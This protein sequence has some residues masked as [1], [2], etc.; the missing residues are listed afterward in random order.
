[1][2][3]LP[4]LHLLQELH[5][6]SLAAHANN[7]LL[8]QAYMLNCHKLAGYHFLISIAA[9]RIICIACFTA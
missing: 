6:H 2:V 8:V 4:E 1:M 7:H 3:L 9:H 5:V